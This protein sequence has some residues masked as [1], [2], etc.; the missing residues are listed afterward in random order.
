[1]DDP[2]ATATDEGRFD[3]F[4]KDM[5]SRKLKGLGPVEN[6]LGMQISYYM[7]D[8]FI[9]DQEKTI[10]EILQR[11]RLE[12]ANALRSPIADDSSLDSESEEAKRLPQKGPGTP[13]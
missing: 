1:M 11:N 4:E 7:E 5:A 2:L 6:F 3:Q 13:K 9:V 10:T 12:K 8:G